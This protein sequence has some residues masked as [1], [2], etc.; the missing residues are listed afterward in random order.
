M[1]LDNDLNTSS[2]ASNISFSSD[3]ENQLFI[4]IKK[5][6]VLKTLTPKQML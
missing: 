1:K 4:P 3:I 5:G 6:T 2:N